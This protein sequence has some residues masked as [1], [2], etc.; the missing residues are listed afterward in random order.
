MTQI[1]TEHNGREIT[2]AENQDIWRCWDLEME[3]STL[4]AL[5]AKLDKFDADQRRVAQVP[6]FRIGS[7]YERPEKEPVQIVLVVAEKDIPEWHKSEGPQVWVV[8]TSKKGSKSRQKVSLSSLMPD[9]PEAAAAYEAF[10]QASEEL[11]LAQASASIAFKA[12]PR[13]SLEAL[14]EVTEGE[15]D[16]GDVPALPGRD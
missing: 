6:A 16:L 9:T 7:M 1:K 14:Q 15:W 2:Y 4:S 10:L 3:A 12:I 11:R 8:P 5:K 13:V